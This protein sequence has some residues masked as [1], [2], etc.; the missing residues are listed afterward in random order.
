MISMSQVLA[1]QMAFASVQGGIIRFVE[2]M[3][4][5]P[6]LQYAWLFL[7]TKTYFWVHL[8]SFYVEEWQIPRQPSVSSKDLKISYQI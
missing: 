5:K 8:F 1:F 2:Q 3:F 6:A 7:A 4:W